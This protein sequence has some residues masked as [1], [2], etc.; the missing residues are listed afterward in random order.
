VAPGKR[1]N[2]NGEP[3]TSAINPV[4]IANSRARIASQFAASLRR[5]PAGP[6]FSTVAA[7]FF[8]T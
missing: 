4:T 5:S 1:K 8:A 7:G 2:D 6:I 3:S